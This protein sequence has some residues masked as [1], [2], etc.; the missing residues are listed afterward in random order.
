MSSQE[1]LDAR[2]LLLEHTE[3]RCFPSW[4]HHN[5]TDCRALAEESD[6]LTAPPPYTSG[7]KMLRF[8]RCSSRAFDMMW[9]WMPANRACQGWPVRAKALARRSWA[10]IASCFARSG[11]FL[12]SDTN[13]DMFA[14]SCIYESQIAIALATAVA[15]FDAS[16]SSASNCSYFGRFC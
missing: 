11:W 12:S 3:I 8:R 16:G 14:I 10:K 15:G 6:L 9:A 13:R 2:R 4:G 5:R 1:I 7:R